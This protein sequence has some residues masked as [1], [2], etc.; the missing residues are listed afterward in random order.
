[1]PSSPKVH[2]KYMREVWY[3][4]NKEKHKQLVAKVNSR[5]K[6]ELQLFI[7]KLKNNP[8]MDCNNKFPPECMDFYHIRGKKLINIAEAVVKRWSMKRVIKELE[9][10]ELVCSNCHRIRTRNRHKAK[11]ENS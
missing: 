1:M 7:N 11:D 3:P 2:A 8:C 5:R 10:C 6:R 9:K 4:K